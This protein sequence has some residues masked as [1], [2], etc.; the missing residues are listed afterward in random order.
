[1]KT[2][3]KELLHNTHYFTR[4]ELPSYIG[5]GLMVLAGILYFAGRGMWTYLS[6][7]VGLPVGFLLFLITS[8]TRSSEK[9]IDAFI[10]LR[11]ED[12]GTEVENDKHYEK[13]SLRRLPPHRVEGYEYA[14]GLLLRRDK[15][16][17]LR[18]SHYTKTAVYAFTT[19]VCFASR[20]LSLVDEETK[21]TRV[22][23][24]YADIRSIRV[25]EESKTLTFGKKT[26]EAKQTCLLVEA[27]N[28]RLAF[29]MQ[30]SLETDEFLEN[31]NRQIALAQKPT[32]A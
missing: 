27:A 18:S 10:A 19:G 17:S 32:E 12:V 24:P 31:L 25:G 14:D 28:V 23:I 4:S 30:A 6:V 11:T 3:K 13:K 15:K 2:N 5:I 1:M 16:G 21:E 20:T 29:P 8:I 9:D 26:F 22:E 7:V